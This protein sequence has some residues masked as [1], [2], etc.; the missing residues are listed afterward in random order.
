MKRRDPALAHCCFAYVKAVL[1]SV[2]VKLPAEHEMPE[3]K[4]EWSSGTDGRTNV[5]FAWE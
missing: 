2:A 1:L 5:K 3:I 4:S